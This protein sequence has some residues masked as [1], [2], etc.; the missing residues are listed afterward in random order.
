MIKVLALTVLVLASVNSALS[1]EYPW[2]GSHHACIV[3]NARYIQADGE[4]TGLWDNAPKTF[5][6]KI[7]R[8]SNY[9]ESMGLHPCEKRNLRN[10]EAPEN[11]DGI[12]FDGLD[13]AFFDPEVWSL[14]VGHPLMSRGGDVIR[15]KSDEGV[16]DYSKFS[17]LDTSY[18]E[19]WFTLRARCTV[20]QR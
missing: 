8:C 3:E 14:I 1:E 7:I 9:T 12:T 13:T 10:P 2:R 20:L 6:M 16:L 11:Y 17:N 5:F 4:R 18:A 19:A 15:L